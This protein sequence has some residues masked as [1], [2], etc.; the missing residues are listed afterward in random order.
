MVPGT[1]IR[2]ALA[3]IRPYAE[4]SII[5]GQY[6]PFLQLLVN[7][8]IDIKIAPHPRPGSDSPGLWYKIPSVGFS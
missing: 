8:G 4:I 1:D 3:W 6:S 7:I 5:S 2:R